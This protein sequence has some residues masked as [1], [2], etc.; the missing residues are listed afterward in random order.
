MPG[1][2][3]YEWN[4][5]DDRQRPL[6]VIFYTNYCG[7]RKG[8]SKQVGRVLK[9]ATCDRWK[10][11]CLQGGNPALGNNLDYMGKNRRRLENKGMGQ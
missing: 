4:G 3:L 11:V 1:K 5:T 9:Q 8:V 10:A 2:S 6:R 7:N